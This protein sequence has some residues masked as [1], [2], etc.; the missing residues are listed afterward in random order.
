[1]LQFLDNL[2]ADPSFRDPTP[3]SE[4]TPEDSG[5]GDY[6]LRL[7]VVYLPAAEAP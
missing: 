4:R 6:L 2:L 7:R 1:M 3:A 5:T